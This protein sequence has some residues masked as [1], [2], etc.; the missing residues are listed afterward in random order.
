MN[1]LIERLRDEGCTGFNLTVAACEAAD[2]LEALEFS[3]AGCSQQLKDAC[4]DLDR[5]EKQRDELR[6][7]IARHIKADEDLINAPYTISK[8]DHFAMMREHDESLENMH[9][10]LGK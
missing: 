3:W 4:A 7:A 8:N 9:K 10:V 2:K 6:A 5:V 1:D